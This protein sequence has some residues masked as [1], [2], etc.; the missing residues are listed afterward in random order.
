MT[1]L[2]SRNEYHTIGRWS[3]SGRTLTIEQDPHNGIY[4]VWM[5][6]KLA[7]D[8]PSV[9]VCAIS[10]DLMDACQQLEGK[11]H[12]MSQ[13]LFALDHFDEL[14]GLDELANDVCRFG[15][16]VARPLQ[17]KGIPEWVERKDFEPVE[18]V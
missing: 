7:D 4:R 8:H 18:G 13:T 17:G 3:V 15:W 5:R 16:N 10:F 2:S 12:I 9:W 14:R 11:I 6:V 1:D